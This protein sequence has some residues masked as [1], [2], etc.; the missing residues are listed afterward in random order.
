MVLTCSILLG[1][2]PPTFLGL[3]SAGF[4]GDGVDEVCDR[5]GFSVIIVVLPPCQDLLSTVTKVAQPTIHKCPPQLISITYNTQMSPSISLNHLPS[6][7]S[8]TVFTMTNETH[9]LN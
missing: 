5:A 2:L 1:R 6:N 7:A 9:Q 8:S 4:G 3:G